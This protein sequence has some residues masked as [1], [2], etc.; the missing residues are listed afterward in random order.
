MDNVNKPAAISVAAT[1][2]VCIAAVTLLVL[3][4]GLAWWLWAMDRATQ[5]E[6]LR[7]LIA[8]GFII[9]GMALSL[10]VLGFMAFRLL[11]K[12]KVKPS[13]APVRQPTRPAGREALYAPLKKHLHARY[14]LRWRRKVRLLLVTGDEAAIEQL[15]PGLCQQRWLEGQRTVLIYGGGLLS[16]PDNQ[17]YAA[18]RKLRRGR[19]LDGIVRV[20]PSSLTLTPQISESDLRGLEKISELLGYAAPVWLWKLC[21]SEWSQA[22]RT[23]QTVGATFPLRAKPDDI[24]GQL[25]RMLPA[26]RAQGMSQVAENNSHDF[27]LRLGQ[28]L[29]DGGIAR[30][31]QQLVPW[32]SVSQQRVPLR[33]LMFSLPENKPTTSPEGT[34]DAE[35]YIPGAHRHA[36]TLPATWQGIVEDC[37]RVRGRRVS[38]AW[39]Q[40]LAWSLMVIIG[41]WGA[42][43]LL[44]FAINR[45]Q[46]VSV[47]EQAHALVEH[48]SVSDYQLTALHNLRNDA[49]RLLHNTEEGTPWYQRFG[50]DHNHQLLDAMLPWYGAANNRLIRDPANVA[51]RQVLSA[52][53]N[54]APNSDQRAQLAKPGYDQLKA[55]L[56]MARP[57]KADGAFFAQTMKAVQPTRTGISTGLWQSLAP[58]LW[59]FY[60]TRLPERPEWKITPDAQRVSQSRQVLLQQIGRRNAESTLYENMLKSVRRNFADVS[61]EEMT[62]GTDARRLFTTDE[63]VPG[64]FTRQAWEGGI[65]QAIDK[66][67]SS[68]REEIDWVLSDSR[69][70]MSTDLSPEALKARLTRRYFTDFAG[71]W[72]NFLNSLRLNPA[73][74]IADV[75]DQLT[76]ISD[77][78]QSPL[79][80]LM[81]TLAWQGQVGQQREGLS[82]SLIK[83]AKDLVG[84]KDKPVIDQSAAGPQGPL[85]D[86]FG[87][88]L[89]LMGKNTGSNVMSADSTLSLQTY[90]TRITRVRLRLQQV[91]NA[92][93]PLEMMQTLAQTVFQGKSVDLTDTQQ[94]GSLISA[95]LGEE[96]SG[97]GNTLFVQPLTQA[98]ETVLLPSAASLN[99]KWRRSVVANW[100]TAFDGRFPFAA[101]KSDAS[102]PMLAEFV[103]KDSGRIERFLTTELNGVLHKEGSQWVPDKVNSHGLVFNPAF[104][105]AINQLSQLSDILFTDGSQ[106]ISFELQA[107]PAP[108]VVETQ[109]TID[110][111]KLRYFNQMTDWQ[112]F[113]W[114]GETYKP[115]TLLTWTTVNAGTRLFGDYS[116]TWGFIRW[117]EQGKRQQLE[118]SQW[119]MSFT[120]PDGRTLQWVLR[121]QLGSGPL[122][123]LAL[124]GL[125]LPDQI[126]TVDAAESAQALTTGV[127]NSDMDEMEL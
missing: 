87:P 82:D 74:N 34:A 104:L 85:D 44:S 61:L 93:D 72:L 65:Q 78:R 117:L 68:R 119:M 56:M 11:I 30:W 49:G 112:T 113:R 109:L 13:A 41:I 111:Q 66:A 96:W 88:L 27:L 125:T 21:D 1:V 89:Q 121:S 58:D 19:P 20:M 101:S 51:L 31:A 67:A 53:V 100:H 106:G 76:L 86:T 63:V 22:K 36:L 116:G 38:M 115:G 79:I 75:T 42:G 107:R 24:T 29:K 114:P 73:T 45:M 108:E 25:E 48:P 81:N 91:A 47:A 15:A 54:S 118:R 23:E 110:G 92:S 8:T 14:R 32:L 124:R 33:G 18:L 10:L 3:L 2:I 120:A 90:L 5:W 17:Q 80:A 95:S 16:E 35:Q 70:T 57:D 77:V 43:I 9:W 39:E 122:A 83:S 127:G 55:W 37:S 28:H 69:K 26:L 94:Y 123:L 52:L 50:L 64:M 46:I 40:T 98:W 60:L 105:R 62:S 12:D 103:R 126:F 84:G 6:T 102:L 59:A 71:S 97:F 7:P 4:G 99:D